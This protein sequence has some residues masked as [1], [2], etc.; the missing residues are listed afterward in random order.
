MNPNIPPVV[1][2]RPI[3]FIEQRKVE[4]GNACFKQLNQHPV[5]NIKGR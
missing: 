1:L 2:G 4:T 3:A 5:P